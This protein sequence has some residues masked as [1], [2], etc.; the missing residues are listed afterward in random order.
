VSVSECE[1]ESVV[2]CAVGCGNSSALRVS[3]VP[4][5]IISRY[6]TLPTIC[7]QTETQ[8]V[9]ADIRIYGCI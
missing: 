4:Q 1:R 9:L 7:T 3:A 2:C 8:A 5:Q 6:T